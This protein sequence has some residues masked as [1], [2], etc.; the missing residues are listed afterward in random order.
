MADDERQDESE[1]AHGDV[2]SLALRSGAVKSVIVIIIIALMVVLV[3]DR[4]TSRCRTV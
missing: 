3:V 4:G 2:I 1:R